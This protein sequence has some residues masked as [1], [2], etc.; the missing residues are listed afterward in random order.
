VHFNMLARGGHFALL[1]E[2]D[3]VVADIRAT[4]RAVR[5]A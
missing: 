5:E 1:K 2:A 3:S 4:F